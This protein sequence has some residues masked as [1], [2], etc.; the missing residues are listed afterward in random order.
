MTIM[1]NMMTRLRTLLH[2]QTSFARFIRYGFVAAG[3]A[4]AEVGIFWMINTGL[5]LH[6]TIAV[7]LSIVFAI[8]LN[9]YLSRVL[10]FRSTNTNKKREFVLTTIVSLIGLCIQLAV[11]SLCVEV[12]GL[13]PVVG[14][15]IAIGVTFFW[16]F[17][18]RQKWIFKTHSDTHE[19]LS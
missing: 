18:S 15:V 1:R 6:Y 11:T 5:G 17:W 13:I 14:K 9:W 10:V 7:V 4:L 8:L 2:D 12:F 3:I 16:N 19:Q